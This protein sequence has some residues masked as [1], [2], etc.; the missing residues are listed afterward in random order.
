LVARQSQWLH[1]AVQSV[2]EQ[3]G[4]SIGGVLA[5][6]TGQAPSIA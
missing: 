4:T 2:P 1:A 5:V 3:H 6:R